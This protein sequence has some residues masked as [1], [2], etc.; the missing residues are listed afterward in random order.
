MRTRRLVFLSILYLTVRTNNT[1]EYLEKKNKPNI[2]RITF[3]EM[4]EM[5]AMTHSCTN[6]AFGQ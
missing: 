5:F 4:S 3:R 1:I 6:L 2:L